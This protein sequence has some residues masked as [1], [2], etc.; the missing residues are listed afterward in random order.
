MWAA[1]VANPSMHVYWTSLNTPDFTAEF[2]SYTP[3]ELSLPATI[4]YTIT[5]PII[6]TGNVIATGLAGGDLAGTYPNPI[7]VGLYGNPISPMTPID[8]AALTWDATKNQYVTSL[9]TSLPPV[10]NQLYAAVIENPA[11]NPVF[12]RLTQDM[13]L[14]AYV[15]SLSGGTFAEVGQPVVHPAFAASYSTSPV[16]AVLT[17]NAGNPPQNVILT[18]TSFSS[19]HTYDQFVFGGTVTFTLTSNGGVVTK[20]SQTTYEW[21]QRTFYGPGVAGGNTAAFIQ[22]LS[23]QF[24]TNTRSTQFTTTASG[25]QHIYF[26]CRTAYG[27]P[28]FIVGGFAGGF[29]LVSNSISVTNAFGYVDTYQLWVSDNVGLGATTVTVE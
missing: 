28:T 29:S 1:L 16:T 10:I 9:S 12:S 8:K 11:G 20:S 25:T 26:A 19:I 4:D 21:V 5:T 27:T 3:S 15:V 24:L 23:G 6:G 22:S 14:P 7:V 17:D 13:I 18:P 2:S